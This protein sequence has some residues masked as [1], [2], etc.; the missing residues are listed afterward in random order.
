MPFFVLR[1]S[2]LYT[3]LL[4]WTHSGGRERVSHLP[5]AAFDGAQDAVG[6][7]GCMY[8]L[9]V[10]TNQ[11]LLSRAA[12]EEFFSQSVHISGTY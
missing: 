7:P 2:D 10:Y 1:A 4:V 9:F 8:I 12:L 3:V 5:L 11:N 6:L